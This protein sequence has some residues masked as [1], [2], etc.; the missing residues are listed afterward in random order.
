MPL[1]YSRPQARASGEAPAPFNQFPVLVVDGVPLAQSGAML[2]YVAKQTGTYPADTWE[3]AVAESQLDQ[4]MDIMSAMYGAAFKPEAEKAAAIASFLADK[5]PTQTK[6]LLAYLGDKAFFGGDG[7]NFVD[8]ALFA[9]LEGA[10]RYGMDVP[11]TVPGGAA[12][13]RVLDGVAAHPK[14]AAYFAK[15]AAVEAE[16]EA[17][18]KAAAGN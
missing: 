1:I 4:V 2:R 18:A 3:A 11:A 10:A 15:R 17:A 9:A 12:L 16:E 8:F 13:Q 6:G 14:L 7:P 5:A